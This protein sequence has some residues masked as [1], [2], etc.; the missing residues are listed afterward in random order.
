MKDK[1]SKSGVLSKKVL[2]KLPG[3]PSERRMKKGSVVV[4]ECAQEIP[5][6]PCESSCPQSAI[7]IGEDINSL[8]VLDEDK[9]TGCGLCISVCPGLAIF[10]IDLTYSEQE[11][12]VQLPHE[13]LPLPKKG[14]TV[15]CLSREGSAVSDG[16]VIKVSNP[17]RNDRTPVVSVAVPKEYVQEVRAIRIRRDG[18]V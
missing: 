3:M 7:T 6:N 12:L 14:D 15:K 11:A 16:K 5:C 2:S 9:C 18:G 17:R 8:P 1:T 10:A 4:I 13:F